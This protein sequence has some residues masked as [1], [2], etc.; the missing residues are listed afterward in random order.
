MTTRLI[1]SSLSGLAMNA[2]AKGRAPLLRAEQTPL[3]PLPLP[4]QHP[5]RAGQMRATRPAWAA[6]MRATDRAPGPSL[7]GHRS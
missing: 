4:R 5:A 3:E 1:L 7:A 2:G 6:A